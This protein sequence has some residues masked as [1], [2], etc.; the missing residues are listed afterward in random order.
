MTDA[1]KMAVETL[2]ARALELTDDRRATRRRLLEEAHRDL[3]IDK[4]IAGCM[5]G[6]RAL[7]REPDI[8]VGFVMPKEKQAAYNQFMAL[9]GQIASLYP[10]LRQEF[11]IDDDNSGVSD[12]V[13][14]SRPEMP[15]IADI[16]LS[17]LQAAGEQGAKAADIRR[18]IFRTY[19]SDIHEKTVGMTLNRMQAAGTVRREGHVWYWVPEAIVAPGVVNEGA[20][21]AMNAAIASIVAAGKTKEPSQK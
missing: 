18:F 1:I 20:L 5:A 14:N 11:G 3:E 21:A 6:I 9:R 15:R 7:G 16:I 19:D 8:P 10:A 12:S 2:A 17:R 13:D 4:D